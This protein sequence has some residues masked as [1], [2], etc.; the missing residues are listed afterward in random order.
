MDES[1]HQEC[2]EWKKLNER[3]KNSPITMKKSNNA[4]EVELIEYGDEGVGV[5]YEGDAFANEISNAYL[6]SKWD[7][8]AKRLIIDNREKWIVSVDESLNR[9]S[10]E[11]KYDKTFKSAKSK[12]TSFK[13]KFR[14]GRSARTMFT[15]IKQSKFVEAD[16]NVDNNEDANI[17]AGDDVNNEGNGRKTAADATAV[18]GQVPTIQEGDGEEKVVG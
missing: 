9:K 4:D 3:V 14:T 13:D 6:N 10:L 18:K 15:K 5:V 12:W 16:G 11:Q 8:F 7:T 2:I 1:D 17:D